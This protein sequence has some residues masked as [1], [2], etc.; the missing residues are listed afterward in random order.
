MPT[1]KSLF[2]KAR[3]LYEL[4]DYQQSLE[5][6][7]K[8]TQSFPE[9]KPASSEK[10]RINERLKEQQTGEYNF[11]Q[12][13]KQAES[14]PPIIDCATFS[15]PVEVRE[16]PGRGKGLFTTKAV[17]AGDLLL[18]EKAFAYSFAGDEQSRKQTKILMNLATKRM[19]VGGQAHL[20]TQI[21]QKLYHNP[22]LSAEFGDLHHADYQ[23]AT[24]LETDGI[25]VVDS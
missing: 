11:D 18:C 15:A 12:M 23:K 10:E 4:G 2:R 9:N 21:V 20:L 24:V 25:P 14:T 16:S 7:E 22:S 13:Y 5:T 1:E 3:A 8:L 6:L 17:S 19:V